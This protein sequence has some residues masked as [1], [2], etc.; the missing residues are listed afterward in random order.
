MEILTPVVGGIHVLS[1]IRKTSVNHTEKSP[2]PS[3]DAFPQFL[4]LD[5]AI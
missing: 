4:N 2:I 3:L 1:L 5:S